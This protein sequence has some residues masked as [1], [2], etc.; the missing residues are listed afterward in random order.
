MSDL[1]LRPEK[2][3]EYRAMEEIVREAF[4]DKYCPGCSEHLVVHRLRESAESVSE[5]CLAAEENGALAGGIWYARAMIRNGSGLHPVLTMG[6]VCVKPG[7]QSRGIGSALIRKTLADAKGR[8]LAPAVVIY[9][10]LNYYR[11]FG[12]RSASDLGIT[13]PEGN[14]HPAILVCP[15]ADNIPSGAFDEGAVYH[16][17]PDEVRVF[18]KAFPHRQKHYHP[19]QLFFAQ[20]SAPP[21]DPLLRRSWELRSRADAFLRES[22]VLEAWESIGGRVRGVGSFR[23]GLMMKHRDIDLHIYT[24]H[25]DEAETRKALAP[26]LASGRTVGLDFLDHADTEE[27]CFEW[28]LRQQ[29]ETGEIWKIDMIQILAGT[30]YDGLIEDTTEAVIDALTSSLRRRILTLKDQCPDDL[31][32]CGLEYYKAVI[33]DGVESW[34]Q[35]MTWRENNPPEAWTNWRP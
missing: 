31:N 1:L 4:W 35:F 2:S 24:D 16:V 26:I 20:P 30:K 8:G 17:S 6:P 19:G 14:F 32:I 33:A 11:R 15:L 7:L 27:H 13:D 5:L 9:G 25:L 10:D 18:D 12:F 28:H 21:E 3:A 22:R 23:S 29:D 34:S